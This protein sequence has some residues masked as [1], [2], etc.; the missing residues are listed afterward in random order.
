MTFLA[1]LLVVAA[2]AFVIWANAKAPCS[3][4]KHGKVAD[5][6]ARCTT[7]YRP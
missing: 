2:F 4:Y 6:P 1:A 7:L 5:I 3:W